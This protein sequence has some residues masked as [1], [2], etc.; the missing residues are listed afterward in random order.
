MKRSP[1]KIAHLQAWVAFEAA[2]R[3]GTFAA[4]AEELSVT[5]AAVS[6]HLRTLETYLGIRL[7]S[8]GAHGVV[9]TEEGRRVLPGVQDGLRSISGAVDLLGHRGLCECVRVSTSPAFASRWL[10]PRIHRFN[11]AHPG[12][13]LNLESTPR[14]VNLSEE[15]VDVAI[16]YGREVSD[17][18]AAERLFEEYVFPVGSPALI[19]SLASIGPATDILRRLPLIHDTNALERSYLP[20]WSGWLAQHGI[21]G[22]DVGRGLF[23]DP[24]LAVQAAVEGRGLLLGRSVIV[25]DDLMAERLVR[26]L[27]QA[28]RSPNCFYLVHVERSRTTS[29]V[30]AFRDWLR[31]EAA[32]TQS[33]CREMGIA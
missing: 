19:G 32:L 29:R 16:R 9:L 15:N 14:V 25:I 27:P 26:P 4:A 24:S 10:L 23:L 6:Q 30:A 11:R 8:R 33:A 5:P 22:V 18:A 3:A 7:F 17:G 20:S 1:R 21:A 31:A 12:I 13:D 2:A 28:V